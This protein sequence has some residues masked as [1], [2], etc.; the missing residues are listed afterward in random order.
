[1]NRGS[2]IRLVID[3]AMTIL[4]LGA[5]AYRIFGDVAHE[6]IGIS[7]F[8]LFAV[9]NTIN[10]RW[11]KGIFK[12]KYT[13]RRTIT[14]IVNIT[15]VFTMAVV[16]VTGLLQSRAVLAFLHLPGD[17]ILRQAHTTAAYWSLPLIGVHAGLHWEMIM[18]AIRKMMRV[19]ESSRARTTALRI[20]AVITVVSYIRHFAKKYF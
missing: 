6:W 9:H 1:M 7:L 11:Y 12:G 13:L 18:N 5:Y 15:L 2:A 8:A 16:L 20:I 10:L 14:T 17:M 19:K 3:L 4:L